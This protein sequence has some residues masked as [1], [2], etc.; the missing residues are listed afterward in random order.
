MSD[1]QGWQPQIPPL[2]PTGPQPHYYNQPPPQYYNQPPVYP[3]PPHWY[4]PVP[5]GAGP[6]RSTKWWWIG[7]SIVAVVI[8][9]AGVVTA[10]AMRSGPDGGA[11]TPEAA[12]LDFLAAL[13]NEDPFAAANLLDPAEQ[14]QI[15]RILDN[16]QQTAQDTSFQEGDDKKAALQG[17]SVST[18]NIHTDVDDLGDNL[19]RVTITDGTVTVA[20][21]PAEA[22]E[23]I[24]D[25]LESDDESSETWTVDDMVDESD[26]GDEI[27]PSLMTVRNGGTWY[28]SLVYSWFDR[29]ALKRDEAPT[30][31]E[32]AETQ[33]FDSPVAAAQGFVEALVE[34]LNDGSI[35]AVAQAVSPS[36][37]QLLLTYDALF[38]DMEPQ[39]VEIVG[40]QEFSAETTGDTATVTVDNLELEFTDDNGDVDTAELRDDCITLDGD[41]RC[42]SL[43]IAPLAA[44]VFSPR[45]TGFVAAKDSTGWHID[46]VATYLGSIADI[47]DNASQE[48]VAVLLAGQFGLSAALLRL[49][50]S[51][52]V[53]PRESTEVRL[54]ADEGSIDGLGVAVIDVP[55]DSGEYVAVMVDFDSQTE[56]SW[57]I[58]GQSGEVASGGPYPN[59][60]FFYPPDTETLRL[61]IWGT[62]DDEVSVSVISS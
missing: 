60:N 11:E 44:L 18:D 14:R 49:E 46:P 59:T 6:R 58:V 26:S 19:A 34:T 5:P 50:A 41:R 4:G 53:A 39:D 27:L 22:D 32:E 55:V 29:L 17:L 35:D 7:G 13:E 15:T 16:A 12:V 30:S 40:A 37:G 54:T 9:V 20:F 21:D 23:G 42:D 56:A 61:V 43:G 8:L 36:N 1:Q 47:G 2:N 57:Q 52:T 28:V 33:S 25:L 3:Q 38:A 51:E 31:V 48:E 45:R 10:V 62:A 24:K